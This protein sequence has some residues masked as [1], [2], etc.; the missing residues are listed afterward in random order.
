MTI[1]RFQKMNIELG[2]LCEPIAP[3]CNSKN[4]AWNGL[5]RVHLKRPE[6]DGNALLE[7]TRIFALELDEE[8][9]IAKVS[10]GFDAIAANAELTLKISSKSLPNLPAHKLFELMVRDSF[11]RNKEFEITQV[12]KGI[13]QEHAYVIAAS[14]DQRSKILRFSLAVEGELITLTPTREKLT[15]AAIA[16]KNCLVLI[17]KNLNK[18]LSSAMVEEGLKTLIG[19][20]NVISVYFLRVEGGMHTGIANIELLN[21][22]IYK[23]FVTKTHKLQSKYVRF[24]PH[25][26]SLDGTAAPSEEALQEWGFKDLNTALAGTVEA[27]ENATTAPK[28]RPTA[29]GEISTLVKEAIAAGTQTL[30]LELKADMQTLR[31][32]ILAESHTYIDI[33]TQDLRSKIEGQS[34]TIVNQF[35]ALMESLSTTRKML[36]DTPQCLALPPPAPRHSN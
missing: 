7:G 10:R 31:E 23:K 32:D 24:N 14:P 35:K 15:A 8:T 20:K 29:K 27:L 1:T 30:K 26:R 25:P 2:E 4:D 6:L 22:P 17:V 5:T 28:Q 21:A 12:L 19:E 34:D 9:T 18:G 33:M 13:D 11:K 36:H 3:L 16:R